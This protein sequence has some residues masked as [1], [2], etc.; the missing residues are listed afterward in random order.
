MSLQTH[1]SRGKMEHI[2][3]TCLIST[4]TAIEKQIIWSPADLWESSLYWSKYNVRKPT[5]SNCNWTIQG[6]IWYVFHAN[7]Q[8]TWFLQG[9][10]FKWMYNEDLSKGKSC[11]LMIIWKKMINISKWKQ[12]FN[13][14][15]WYTHFCIC[16]SCSSSIARSSSKYMSY[17]LKVPY[18]ILSIC[19]IWGF[20]QINS[21]MIHAFIRGELR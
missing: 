19:E 2:L 8:K 21:N 6:H 18:N 20:V 14:L 15:N 16:L 11:F 10:H 9:M 13:I 7:K 5:Q 12:H 3:V 17:T 1:N 4:L